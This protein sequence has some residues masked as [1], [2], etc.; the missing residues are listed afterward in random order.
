MQAAARAW[1]VPAPSQA[2]IA[3]ATNARTSGSLKS[4]GVTEN[5]AALQALLNSL[6]A[7][8]SVYFPAGTYRI[9]GPIK[10]TKPVTLFGEAGTIFNCKGATQTVF[11]INPA[12]TA[13]SRLS[14][15]S[16][17]GVV[18]EG[19]GVRPIRSWSTQSSPRT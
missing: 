10:I 11:S 4:D 19:P 14:G 6:P 2:Q 12:G 9:S 18:I 1:T 7:G 17:T 8:A 5:T 13:T 15:V 16:I 3:A